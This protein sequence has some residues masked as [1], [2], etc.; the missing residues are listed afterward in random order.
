VIENQKN[1]IKKSL[2]PR[3][4][5]ACFELQHAIIIPKGTILRQP[6]GAPGTFDCP[7]AGGKFVVDMV[8]AMGDPVT[9]KRVVA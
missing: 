5:S 6:E 1:P 4:E 7:V 2:P 8:P 3:R 9:Y